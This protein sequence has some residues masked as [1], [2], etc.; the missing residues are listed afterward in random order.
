MLIND[1]IGTVVKTLNTSVFP[2]GT[3]AKI[4]ACA[5]I[6]A[7]TGRVYC[8]QTSEDIKGVVSGL[9]SDWYLERDLV[10]VI[11]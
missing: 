5:F 1:A 3:K 11:E 2:K 9:K 10:N 8:I 7:T 6:G 4:I